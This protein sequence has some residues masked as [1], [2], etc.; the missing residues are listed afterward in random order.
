MSSLATL[1][2]SSLRPLLAPAS[3]TPRSTLSWILLNLAVAVAYSIAGLVV[4]LFGIGPAKISPVYPPAGIAVAATLILGPRILPAVF[5]GQFLNGFP[6]LELPQTTVA[7]YLLANTGTGIG[8]ILEALIA[9]S[10]LRR[11][12]GTWHPFDRASHVVIFLI[13]SCI[14]A[15]IV[16]G[17]IGTFSLWASGFVP[18][19]DFAI[20]FVTF[21][22]ADAAGIAVFG[23]LALA[24]YRT[25]QLDED[26][27]ASSALIVIIVL[28]IAVLGAWS[29]YPVDYLFLPLLLWAGF[30]GGPRGVTLAAAAITV[31]TI[32]ATM[33]GVG[34]FVGNTANESILLLQGFM[35]VITFTGL[36]VVAV[37]AQQLEADDALAAHNRMLERRVAERTAEVAEKNRLLEEK[38]ARIDDDLKMTQALQASILPTDFSAYSETGIAAFMK[39]A[40]EVGGDFYDVFPMQHG[41][42]GLVV[43][44]VSGKGVAAAFFMAVT[45][46]ML[47]GVA[48]AGSTPSDCITRVNEA[49]CRENPMD[50][51]VTV[52]YAELE[53]A[54]GTVRFVNA[55]HCEP[56]L[57]DAGGQARLLKR[58]GNPP[59]GVMPDKAF[60]ERSLT[61]APG[62]MLFLY[63]DGVTEAVNRDG[64]QFHARRLLDTAQRFAGRSPQELM[65]AV[66]GDV[67]S[68][69]AGTVQADDITCLV[70]RR[71][72]AT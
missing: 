42:L 46:T 39:P 12:N 26:V 58:S 9:V 60:A 13:G 55:G 21:F 27:L 63:T 54:S 34:S 17:A 20:T 33:Y 31:V 25:P 15:A 72:V 43:A 29:R 14:A 8:S 19:D 38:Q 51:F 66:V 3:S 41:R 48:L 6:L 70:V 69:S 30:R 32:L 65:L 35:A 4:V 16:C 52:L 67:E 23:T 64:D 36:L 62:E 5:I 24:W 1:R 47:K 2:A 45:R 40:L 28:S 10:V 11:F 37:R 18:D 71:N 56:I 22:L 68:F 61:L 59:L 57:T 50:M 49:L 44:D 53:E 7:M